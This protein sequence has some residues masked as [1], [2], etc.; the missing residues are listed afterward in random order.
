MGMQKEPVI[1]V[2]VMNAVKVSVQEE[3][4]LVNLGVRSDVFG[5][6]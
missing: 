6:E 5:Y 2:T 1:P 4:K 3:G